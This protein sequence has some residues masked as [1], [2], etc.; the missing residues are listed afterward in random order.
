MMFSFH[1]RC[2]QLLTKPKFVEHFEN[3]FHLKISISRKFMGICPIY[4]IERTDYF[5]YNFIQ[6]VIL[7][8]HVHFLGTL[9]FILNKY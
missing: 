6:S 7:T 4:F 3:R 2:L 9:C 8:S 1:I 5:W